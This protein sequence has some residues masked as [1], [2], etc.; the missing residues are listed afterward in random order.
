MKGQLHFKDETQPCFVVDMSQSKAFRVYQRYK[1]NV[2]TYVQHFHKK[3]LPAGGELKASLSEHMV[4]LLEGTAVR[5]G[6]RL[7]DKHPQ[8][9]SFKSYGRCRRELPVTG[10][11]KQREKAMA[12]FLLFHRRAIRVL[13]TLAVE[14][15]AYYKQMERKKKRQR[16]E[17]LRTG[18]METYK[19]LVRNLTNNSVNKLLQATGK[20]LD[21]LQ[22]KLSAVSAPSSSS[23]SNT[24]DAPNYVQ[25]ALVK[26]GQLRDYQ[27]DGVKVSPLK[28]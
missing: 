24:E 28:R 15:V 4:K 5:V 11:W 22:S 14:A 27:R 12:S 26:G 19:Q 3:E 10:I 2:A 17:A 6:L 18:D 9:R 7:D 13:R 1:A 16:L 21:R 23:S 8:L 20:F 25:S